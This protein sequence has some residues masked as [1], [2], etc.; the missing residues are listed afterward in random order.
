MVLM[1]IKHTIEK[2]TLLIVDVQE[3]NE[4]LL[5]REFIVNSN[6]AEATLPYKKRAIVFLKQLFRLLTTNPLKGDN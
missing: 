5:F 4:N 2:T 1:G 3:I 6:S